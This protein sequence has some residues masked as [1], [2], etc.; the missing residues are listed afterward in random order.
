MPCPALLL[1][2]YMPSYSAHITATHCGARACPTVRRGIGPRAGEPAAA[3]GSLGPGPAMQCAWLAEG[4][5][6]PRR[7]GKGRLGRRRLGRW[8]LGRR[9]LGNRRPRKA[10][11]RRAR[12]APRARGRTAAGAARRL[13]RPGAW[14]AGSQWLR[15][16]QGDK[17][18]AQQTETGTQGGQ[19]RRTNRARAGLGNKVAGPSSASESLS[20]PA[21]PPA[22]PA[23]CRVRTLPGP[24]PGRTGGP[25]RNRCPPGRQGASER[26]RERASVSMRGRGTAGN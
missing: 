11:S 1:R 9:R 21:P 14:D 6:L 7:H 19:K 13:A 24:G 4:A 20:P 10:A 15:L 2:A 18:G 17:T 22:E 25:P 16:G 26:V 12:A 23:A 8:R 5:M 3:A